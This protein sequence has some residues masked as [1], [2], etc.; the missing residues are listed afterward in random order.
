MCLTQY[1]V[2]CIIEPETDKEPA[3]DGRDKG[4]FAPKFIKPLLDQRVVCGQSATLSV[5][6]EGIPQPDVSWTVDDEEIFEDEGIAFTQQGNLYSLEFK[7]T[8]EEDE[9]L[10]KCMAKN[11]LGEVTCAAKFII[12]EEVIKPEFLQKLNDVEVEEADE[13]KFQT[14]VTGI[15]E[16]E[17]KW[18]KNEDELTDSDKVKITKEGQIV[19]MVIRDC[20]VDDVGFYQVFAVNEA[21]KASSNAQ[22]LVN[23]KPE[24]PSIKTA[25]DLPPK[26]QLKHG[27]RFV[28]ELVISGEVTESYWSKNEIK[29]EESDRIKTTIDKDKASL[30]VENVTESDEGAY[31]FIAI[32]SSGK[33]THATTLNV[34][35]ILYF[36]TY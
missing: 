24:P 2:C 3:G 8:V 13:A 4:E 22:L 25:E 7:E 6:I 15:P 35:G 34:E 36:Y 30:V 11:S 14:E 33:G 12:A 18:L 9:G 5:E 16:P 23:K 10:Y 19:S 29:L 32:N 26:L 28:V 27:E 21:G 20:S 1:P 17:I 31:T